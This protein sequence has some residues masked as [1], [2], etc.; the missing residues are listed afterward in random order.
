MGIRFF[1]P[2][3]GHKMNVKTFLA[4]KRGIC[5]KCDARVDI[6]LESTRTPSDQAAKKSG[7]T[8]AASTSTAA[9]SAQAQATPTGAQAQAA[10]TGKAAGGALGEPSSNAPISSSPTASEPSHVTGIAARPTELDS[11]RGPT[12]TKGV[13]ASAAAPATPS[14]PFAAAPDAV[15]YVRP[16]A[17]G[18]FGPAPTDAM[19][20]WVEEGRVTPDSLVW[21]EGWPDWRRADEVL[22]QLA[23]ASSAKP[24]AQAVVSVFSEPSVM[25]A[26]P[27]PDAV[28]PALQR[29]RRRQRG[30]GRVVAV[31]ILLIAALV[32]MGVLIWVLAREA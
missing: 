25:G 21:C 20:E 4:G 19:Q 17:G 1:C 24:R 29:T 13:S 23:G 31:T 2:E 15:W 10:P 16:P 18:Q 14:D 3:C 22:P 30:S 5:P 9:P 32:L 27:R 7:V 28:D 12:T 26:M 6:P 11:E 8:P